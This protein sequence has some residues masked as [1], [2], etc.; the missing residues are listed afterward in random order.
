MVSPKWTTS[1]A[2]W[3]EDIDDQHK[4]IFAAVGQLQEILSASGSLREILKTLEHL[5]NTI[6]GHFAHEERLMRASRYR[7][8]AW[9]TQ[10]HDA[11]RR[12]VRQLAHDIG[13]GDRAAGVRL[14]EYLTKWLRNHT[15][16][17]DRMMGAHLRN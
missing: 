7:S 14:V 9:H 8:L 3:I 1:E 5:A 6:V 2:V 15:R 12:K 10:Q 4:E 11:A 17:A 13:K 16:I